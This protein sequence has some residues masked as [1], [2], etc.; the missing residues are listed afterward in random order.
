MRA[1]H[2]ELGAAAEATDSTHASAEGASL[3]ELAATVWRGAGPGGCQFL[4]RMVIR[5]Q[6][7]ATTANALL[8]PG[9]VTR[10]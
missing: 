3:G 4:G 2:R 10:Q 7:V 6:G 1:Y 9:N 5:R 8:L